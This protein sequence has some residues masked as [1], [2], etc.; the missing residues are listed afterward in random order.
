MAATLL[1]VLGVSLVDLVSNT[2]TVVA[3]ARK[4]WSMFPTR[5]LPTA[6]PGADPSAPVLLDSAPSFDFQ[7]RVVELESAVV[8]LQE[9]MEASSSVITQLAEQ[10]SQLVAALQASLATVLEQVASSGVTVQALS[11]QSQKLSL[12]ADR[13]RKSIARVSMALAGLAVVVACFALLLV[14]GGV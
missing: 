7:P 9:Q 8:R 1:S 11:D 10:N 13:Q 12:V 4:L 5:R 14:K 3:A 2:P 6:L